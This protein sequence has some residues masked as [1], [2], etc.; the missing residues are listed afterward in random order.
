MGKFY[1]YILWEVVNQLILVLHP[2]YKL[3]YF[4]NIGWEKDWINTAENIVRAEFKRTYADKFKNI[5]TAP[6]PDV[7]M[8]VRYVGF[9]AYMAIAHIFVVLFSIEEIKQYF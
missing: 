4:H 1:F 2:R 6:L 5:D 3:Q 8:T 7:S 9:S